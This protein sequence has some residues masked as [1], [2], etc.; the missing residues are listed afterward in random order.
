MIAYDNHI[1]GI[2][3]PATSQTNAVEILRRRAEALAKKRGES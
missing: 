1:H 3:S 2:K